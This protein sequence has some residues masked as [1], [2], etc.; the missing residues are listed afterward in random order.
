[1]SAKE[2]A[3]IETAILS[4]SCDS[5]LLKAATERTLDGLN[6][7]NS[8]D[9]A[10]EKLAVNLPIVI[11]A[12]RREVEQRRVDAENLE[13][14]KEKV[15]RQDAIEREATTEGTFEAEA[16]A[17]LETELQGTAATV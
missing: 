16:L 6:P 1:M 5:K 3:A 4:G 2:K 17:A 12:N 8:F 10:G 14:L 7:K 15:K 9:R 11:E 13:R